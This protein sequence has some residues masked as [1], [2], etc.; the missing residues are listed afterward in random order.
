MT[1]HK[2]CTHLT[3]CSYEILSSFAR[4]FMNGCGLKILLKLIAM[5]SITKVFQKPSDIPK[6]GLVIGLLS[7]LFKL[8]R[9]I[10]NRDAF[11][12]VDG[13]LKIFL[14]GII[15]SLALQLAS[16]SDLAMLK[17]MI[18]PRV[19]ECIYHYL[20]DQGVIPVFKHGDILLYGVQV[21]FITY[22]YVFEKDNIA[23]GLS[24]QIASYGATYQGDDI[25]YLAM[26]SRERASIHR[27]YGANNMY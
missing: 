9:C 17:L 15:C 18:Y 8:T 10:L 7:G 2:G 13:R 16:K 23:K 12:Q 21:M 19:I 24:N 27:K 22:S 5:R 26:Q 25:T 3:S 4:N 6:F 1:D 14:Q 20:R 11:S